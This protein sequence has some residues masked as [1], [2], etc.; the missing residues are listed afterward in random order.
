MQAG[1][2]ISMLLSDLTEGFILPEIL[3]TGILGALVAITAPYG[4]LLFVSISRA[5]AGYTNRICGGVK[6]CRLLSGAW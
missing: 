6:V 3:T 1:A 4:M 2:M 5:S